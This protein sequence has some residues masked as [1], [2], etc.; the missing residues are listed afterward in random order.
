MQPGSNPRAQKCFEG[1]SLLRLAENGPALR[2]LMLQAQRQFQRVG[3]LAK[4][5]QAITP[6]L[7][8]ARSRADGKF[9]W[10]SQR[11]WRRPASIAVSLRPLPAS[12]RARRASSGEKPLKF[13]R[14]LPSDCLSSTPLHGQ[15]GKAR[16]GCHSLMNTRH[17]LSSTKQQQVN[18]ESQECVGKLLREAWTLDSCNLHAFRATQWNKGASFGSFFKDKIG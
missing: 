11:F 7:A 14:W 9:L 18:M 17:E 3:L 8:P 1:S 15:R 12:A 16:G 13:S 5:G 6:R 2:A 10:I 4:T